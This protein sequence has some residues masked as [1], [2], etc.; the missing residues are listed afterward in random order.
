[1]LPLLTLSLIASPFLFGVMNS[2]ITPSLFHFGAYDS[3]GLQAVD[4]IALGDP[5]AQIVDLEPREYEGFR[6]ALVVYPLLAILWIWLT[7]I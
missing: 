5:R 7:L 1:M 6:A 4:R 3:W 2:S